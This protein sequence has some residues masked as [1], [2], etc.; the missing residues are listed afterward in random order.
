MLVVFPACRFASAVLLTSLLLTWQS[1]LARLPLPL[2]EGLKLAR[3]RGVHQEPGRI[4]D[5]C[6]SCH[7]APPPSAAVP[8]L[9]VT[10]PSLSR[11]SSI[12]PHLSRCLLSKAISSAF[13]YFGI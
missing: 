2:N 4:L 10:T 12:S 9:R 1:S 3:C 13:L 5:R 7:R 6:G 11:V 8:I